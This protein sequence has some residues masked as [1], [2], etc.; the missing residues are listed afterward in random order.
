MSEKEFYVAKWKTVTGEVDTMR[1]QAT[2]YPR[3]DQH[4][5]TAIPDD[6]LPLL[7]IYADNKKML[8]VHSERFIHI[9]REG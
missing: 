9:R 1:F 2:S 7:D 3:V 5:Q 6:S 8:T 4:H